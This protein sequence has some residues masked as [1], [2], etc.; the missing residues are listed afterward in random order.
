V[1]CK[2]GRWAENCFRCAI[3]RPRPAQDARL[4]VGTGSSKSTSSAL[5]SSGT[6]NT[7]SRHGRANK[8]GRPRVALS[9]QRRKARER[10]RAYR[11]RHKQVVA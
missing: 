5:K 6:S 10:V 1:M 4:G 3:S 8:S 2:H 7:V 11:N 9:E